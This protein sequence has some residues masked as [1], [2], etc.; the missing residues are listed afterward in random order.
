MVSAIS[1]RRASRL[2]PNTR[3]SLQYRSGRDPQ[4]ALRMRLRELAA[5]P[6]TIWPS[7]FEGSPEARRVAGERETDLSP[8]YRGG[9]HGAYEA[10]RQGCVSAPCTADRG[11]GAQSAVAWGFHE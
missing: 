10:P 11:Y 1:E 4:D 3:A 2:I 7:A 9:H 6:S 8:V 5:S